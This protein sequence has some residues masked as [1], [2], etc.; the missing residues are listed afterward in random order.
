MPLTPYTA[1]SNAS[2]FDPSYTDD[3]RN[4][5]IENGFNVATMGNGT[6]DSQW[7]ACAAC[8]VLSRSLERSNTAIPAAC[9]S[10]FQKYCWNGT[11]DSTPVS[12]FEP[13][14]FLQL[15]TLSAAG[16]VR[17]GGLVWALVGVAGLAL[18]L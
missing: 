2:T 13:T 3:E 5:F 15:T 11:T 4:A 10:C 1:Y 9:Q 8:A 17:M 12:S 6:V 7:P 18:A 14:P 16:N